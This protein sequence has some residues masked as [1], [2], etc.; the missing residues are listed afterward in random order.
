MTSPTLLK[1]T[2]SMHHVFY[3]FTAS[4]GSEGTTAGHVVSPHSIMVHHGF[5]SED[6]RHARKLNID[7]TKHHTPH[8]WL[9]AKVM[10]PA[11]STKCF[12]W[13]TRST[14]IVFV[15]GHSNIYAIANGWKFQFQQQFA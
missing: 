14:A 9:P 12:S 13:L 10:Y 15:E 6:V 7:Y 3:S 1:T 2:F 5:R 8:C 4:D 11:N